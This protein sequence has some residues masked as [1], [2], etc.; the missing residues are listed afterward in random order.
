MVRNL[1]LEF[2]IDLGNG[3]ILQ[4][5]DDRLSELPD[6]LGIEPMDKDIVSATP[7]KVG[8]ISKY[9]MYDMRVADLESWPSE[10]DFTYSDIINR[11]QGAKPNSGP[12]KKA[13]SD[14]V[15]DKTGNDVSGAA[16][17]RTLGDDFKKLLSNLRS[18]TKA[19]FKGARMA[20][21]DESASSIQA[22]PAIKNW[23][24]N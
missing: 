9:E 3:K 17:V 14:L 21:D 1:L 16:I 15:S 22:V 11:L 7:E 5:P 8:D 24:Q 2:T 10:W 6:L 18:P 12:V 20:P 13:M 19:D 4:I 23:L